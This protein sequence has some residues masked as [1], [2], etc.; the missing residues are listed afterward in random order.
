MALAVPLLGVCGR[1]ARAQ[2]PPVVRAANPQPLRVY[3]GRPE[4]SRSG[5]KIIVGPPIARE[6]EFGGL[7]VEPNISVVKGSA[8]S[9]VIAGPPLPQIPAVWAED[10]ETVALQPSIGGPPDAVF[11]RLPQ[12]EPSGAEPSSE[13]LADGILPGESYPANPAPYPYPPVTYAEPV[14]EHAVANLKHATDGLRGLFAVDPC[15]CGWLQRLVYPPARSYSETGIGSERVMHAPMELDT[16]QPMNNFRIRLDMAFDLEFPDRAELFWARTGGARRLEAARETVVD[17]QDI[18]A[19][20]EVGGERLSVQTELPIRFVDPVFNPNN[21]GFGD[22]SVTTK[23]V[24]V[25]GSTWQITQIFRTIMNTGSPHNG[26]GTGHMS[27]EP[28][29]LARYKCSE[30]DYLHGELKYL[31]PLGG[32]PIHQGQVLRFGFGISHVAYETDTFAAL[33]VLEIVGWSLQDGEETPT[34]GDPRPSDGVHVFNIYEG[35]RFVADTNS[36]LG[37]WE[38]GILGGFNCSGGQFYDGLLRLDMR[39]SF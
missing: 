19:M 18:R 36:D 23:T 6:S 10:A 8:A 38:F 22:M 35:V 29:F 7:L 16:S 26:T 4:L 13:Q 37:L 9:D 31:F 11:Q 28:G 27:L 21:A 24:L 14:F 17:Y 2:P 1:S 15:G 34:A 12:L 3:A 25:N 30:I 32:D 33:P 20:I 39:W 5:R